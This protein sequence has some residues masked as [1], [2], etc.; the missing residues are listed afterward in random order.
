MLIDWKGRQI[1]YEKAR[2]NTHQDCVRNSQKHEARCTFV[3]RLLVVMHL[4]EVWRPS[5]QKPNAP[6]ARDKNYFDTP[7]M[8]DVTMSSQSVV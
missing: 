6:M 2:T 7:S 5:E 3:T 1:K 4:D 8:E